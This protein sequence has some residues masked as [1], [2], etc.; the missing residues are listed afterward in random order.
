MST[1][2]AAAMR[3]LPL[4]ERVAN[5]LRLRITSLRMHSPASTPEEITA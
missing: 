4:E 2:F 5:R 3:G 1:R